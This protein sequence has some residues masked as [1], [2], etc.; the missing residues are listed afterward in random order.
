[1][2]LGLALF[3]ILVLTP[4]T[5][6]AETY[7][8]GPSGTYRQLDELPTLAPGDVVEVEGG[9]TYDPIWFQD[10]G[11]DGNPIVIRGIRSGAGERPRLEGGTN[12]IELS[13][14]HY[15]LEG[16]DITGGSSRCVYHHAHDIVIRDVVIHDCPS[17][18]LLGA[19]Q[20]S[21]SLTL[22]Y[23]EIY[24]T[25]D[26][27]RRHQ[28]YMSTDQIAHPGSVFRMQFCYLHDG[29]GG[30]GVKSRAER[31]EIYYNWI[32]GSY[33]HELELIGPDPGGTP[34]AEDAHREDSDVVGNV[35]V[36]TGINPGHWVVRFG[37]DATGQT[38]G[39]Y[40]FAYNTVILAPESAGVFRLFDGIES[41]E[42]HD[43]VIFSTGSGDPQILRD[44]DAAWVGGTRRVA[45]SHNWLV[46]GV[47]ERDV[48]TEWTGTIRGADPMLESIAGHDLRPADGSPLID[49]ADESPMAVPGFDF[50][51]PELVP[52]FQPPARTLLAVGTAAPR[53]MA[54][55]GLDIGA[56]E[57]GAGP[58]V[59]PVDA[60][61]MMG[62]VD[63]GPGCTPDCGGAVCGDDG[64]GGSC[65]DCTAPEV[66][67]AGVCADE[68]G[69]GTTDCGGECVD[70]SS[71][72][73]HC[74]GCGMA[75]AREASCVMS[76]CVAAP[77]VDA[78]PGT[79]P[80]GS[81][82]CACRAGAPRRSGVL[83]P[84]LA[85]LAAMVVVRR[86]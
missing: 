19:D 16:F 70:L 1:M 77:A 84:V 27:D 17:H 13:G 28:V 12:T 31:N 63:A 57:N 56:Y 53:P 79:T 39:R 21:G 69:A 68:C 60:G 40:R 22:E 59:M 34:V 10:D 24:G 5:A 7:S 37:G 20:D 29:N 18:G 49:A 11:A 25:G 47:G 50:P 23:S 55:S 44:A 86:R 2:R 78:G 42:A 71:D 36:K 66:C 64:C 45:G 4:W 67:A 83:W 73:R 65:G 82:G 76:A 32:E 41:L 8:V 72:A 85:L 62:M 30:N 14:D 75:C 3:S 48:P 81:D 52:L 35:F 33:Y 15:V 6:A 74:G 46:M 58:P 26:A 61:P 9:A 38:N 54:G 51:S 80:P 43:N